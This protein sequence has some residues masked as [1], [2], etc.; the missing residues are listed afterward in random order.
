MRYINGKSIN[1]HVKKVYIHTKFINS[2]IDHTNEYIDSSI[3]GKCLR[4]AKYYVL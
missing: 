2:D 4:H 1:F 3:F